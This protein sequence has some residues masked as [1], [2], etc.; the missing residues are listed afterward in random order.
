MDSPCR[1]ASASVSTSTGPGD[2]EPVVLH[3]PDRH[4]HAGI[5][6]KGVPPHRPIALGG[7]GISHARQPRLVAHGGF[8]VVRGGSDPALVPAIGP[9]LRRGNSA[10]SRRFPVAARRRFRIDVRG[11]R[12]EGS[13]RGACCRDSFA[14]G[15]RQVG[16]RSDRVHVAPAYA[17][18]GTAAL[19]TTPAAWRSRNRA[20]AP[21]RMD[22]DSGT[23]TRGAGRRSDR[24]TTRWLAQAAEPRGRIGVRCGRDRQRRPQRADQPAIPAGIIGRNR[25]HRQPRRLRGEC[26][27]SVQDELDAF[28][29][30]RASASAIAVMRCEGG[31]CRPS[32]TL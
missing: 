10:G 11:C 24:S 6:G 1:A 30:A 29:S 21:R 13:P 9:A 7:L 27:G 22:A 20:L 25:L 2:V 31:G 23:T 3:P 4:P 28:R 5:T 8:G 17:I 26:Q 15:R 16:R 32:M 12:L 18:P 19:P 14:H